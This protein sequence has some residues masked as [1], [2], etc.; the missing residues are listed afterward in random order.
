MGASGRFFS[1]LLRKL[2]LA[3]LLVV[4]GVTGV[5]LGLFLADKGDFDLRRQETVRALTGDIAGL[6]TDLAAVGTRLD[7]ARTEL[8]AQRERAAQ[9][10][11][12]AIELEALSSGF[13][14][15]TTSS[16]QL[17]ENEERRERMRQMVADSGKRAA[18]LVQGLTRTQW[19]KDGLE[20]A[21]ARKQE[22]LAT[23]TATSSAALHYAREAWAAG[24][25]F[26]LAGVALVMLGPALWRR[27]RGRRR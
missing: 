4:L 14:R 25:K 27:R 15:V 21:M 5:G 23:A 22:Q 12:V 3:L 20:I 13:N 1:W 8:A 26:V 7:V 11:K 6:G 16:E 18:E 10:A 17:R 2:A 9:A 19:E 24:G